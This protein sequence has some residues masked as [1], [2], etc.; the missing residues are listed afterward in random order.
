MTQTVLFHARTSWFRMLA[1]PNT[2][3]W[4]SIVGSGYALAQRQLQ[5]KFVGLSQCIVIDV[6][7]VV[8]RG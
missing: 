1:H 3:Y 5:V 7:L 4:P 6:F 2:A 8:Q